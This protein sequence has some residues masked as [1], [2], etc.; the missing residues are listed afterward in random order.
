V[1]LR[2]IAWPDGASLGELQAYLVT[3][4]FTELD[5]TYSGLAADAAALARLEKLSLAAA[6]IVEHDIRGAQLD[7]AGLE[8]V[9]WYVN[10]FWSRVP[11]NRGAPQFV[12]F[13]NLVYPRS[14][15]SRWRLW[16]SSSPLQRRQLARRLEAIFAAR[17]GGVPRLVLNELGPVTL[18]HVKQWF[19]LNAVFES[20]KERYETAER[21][22]TNERGATVDSLPMAEVELALSRIHADFLKR[23]GLYP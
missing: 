8:L 18:D 13:L 9:D 23:K 10:E 21:L 11:E 2:R 6:V 5:A 17:A 19:R 15:P 3:D 4:L 7:R 16:P 1:L 14:R 12:V 22:F 20:D